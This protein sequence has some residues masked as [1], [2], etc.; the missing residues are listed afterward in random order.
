MDSRSDWT[1]TICTR[2]GRFHCDEV[3]ATAMLKY[4]YNISTLSLIRTRDPQILKECQEDPNT[5]V[6]DVGQIYDHD[7]LCYDHHQTSFNE[8][9]SGFG[10]GS[11]PM[12]PLSSCGL[13]YR[14]YGHAI[15]R[16]A[17]LE[18]Y[19]DYQYSE[20]YLNDVYASYYKYFVLSIDANDNG[21]EYTEDEKWKLY[22]PVILPSTVANFNSDAPDNDKKQL[23]HFHEA[24][25]YCSLT[26]L[27]HLVATI[28]RK[29]NYY[30]GLSHFTAAL[31]TS[32]DL[33]AE[34]IL[35][36]DRPLPVDQY[37]KEYDSSQHYKF[38]LVPLNGQWKLWTVHKK[39]KRFE[40]LK[41][42]ISELKAKEIVGDDL[43]FIHKT[44]FTGA[45]KTQDA[46]I[47]IA[48]ASAAASESDL[49]QNQNLS[50]TI[51]AFS[52]LGLGLIIYYIWF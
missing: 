41:P 2:S 28:R 17:L 14:H 38:V 33:H 19:P 30:D 5:I 48:R 20:D 10:F 40:T 21:I 37:L 45:A 35:I 23:I 26:F 22:D 42:L 34:G 1:P 4:L 9:L 18:T 16:K 46:A 27:N 31:T 47:A 7:N 43:V 15:I 44:G 3:T 32:N 51:G 24:V 11:G 39:G 12:I 36:L 8:P 49:I 50:Y 29:K 52:A 25:Q 6:I 13:I